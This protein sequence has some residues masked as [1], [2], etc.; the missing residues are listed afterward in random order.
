MRARIDFC[1]GP[2]AGSR[3]SLAGAVEPLLDATVAGDRG[4]YTTAPDFGRVDD[5]LAVRC[6]ARAF[7]ERA[8][9]QHLHLPRRVILQRDVEATAVAAHEHEALAV[10]QGRGDTL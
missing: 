5:Q 9:R 6:D 1:S 2:H 7:V 8:L 3:T 10:G 4:Q